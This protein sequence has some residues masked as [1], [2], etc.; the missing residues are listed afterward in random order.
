[1][2]WDRVRGWGPFRYNWV[3]ICSKHQSFNEDCNLCQTGSWSNNWKM[4]ISEIVYN[5]APNFWRW[6][7][8]L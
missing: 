4:N 7:I 6:W 8:N 2:K 5:L 3:S 1:M